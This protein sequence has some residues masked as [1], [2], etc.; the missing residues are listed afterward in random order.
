[1]ATRRNNQKWLWR[2][3]GILIVVAIIVAVLI[4]VNRSMSPD[5]GSAND[6][7]TQNQTVKPSENEEENKTELQS[8]TE[9]EEESEGEKVKQYEGENPNKS[10]NLTGVISYAGVSG[11]NLIVR[12][13]IDQYLAEGN[14]K[15][16]LIKDGTTIYNSAAEIMSSVSTSTCN[17]FTVSTAGLPKGKITVE[18]TLESSGK[19]GKMVGE[20][21]I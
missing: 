14:C 3:T 12:V 6:S 2:G 4:V 10:E 18:I 16:A 7:Q 8:Q 21:N 20:L 15:L 1:M 17:G 9:A 13:N 5:T 19:Y 11:S